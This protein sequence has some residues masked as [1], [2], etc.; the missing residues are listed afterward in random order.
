MLPRQAD[1]TLPPTSVSDAG[2]ADETSGC[3]TDADCTTTRVE[4]GGCCPMLCAP[5]VVTRERAQALE[6]NITACSKGRPLRRAP[7]CRPPLETVLPA[8]VQNR[9]VPRSGGAGVLTGYA[10][11]RGEPGHWRR[12]VDRGAE[13]SRAPTRSGASSTNAWAQR[14]S[15]VA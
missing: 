9:C 10:R 8:C 15:R 11:G 1:R 2:P 13:W 6:A 3:S 12:R 7:F 5:R 14:P 4:V